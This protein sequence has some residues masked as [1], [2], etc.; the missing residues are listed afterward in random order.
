MFF[1]QKTG[2]DVNNFDPDFTNEDAVLTPI[3]DA[4]LPQINQDEFQEFSFTSEEM[5]DT[6][7]VTAES[8]APRRAT[9]RLLRTNLA[10]TGIGTAVWI[11]LQV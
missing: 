6:F 11:S 4:V 2:E 7:L 5:L 9:P 3:E 1:G 8:S 10:F